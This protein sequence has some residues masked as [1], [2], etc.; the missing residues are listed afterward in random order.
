MIH[1]AMECQYELFERRPDG[2][3]NWRGTVQE[4]DMARLRVKLL[5]L[6][7]DNECFAMQIP[8]RQVIAHAPASR[9]VLAA[10]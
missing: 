10:A 1:R 3:L 8:G 6:E 7:T 5:A 2:V 9:P 4:L